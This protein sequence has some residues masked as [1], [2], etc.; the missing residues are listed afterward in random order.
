MKATPGPNTRMPAAN[1]V[2]ALGSAESLVIRLGLLAFAGSGGFGL[3]RQITTTATRAT[4]PSASRK[5]Y[6]VE[7]W[8]GMLSPAARIAMR[9]AAPMMVTATMPPST[10]STVM[11]PGLAEA[12]Y[13]AAVS[14]ASGYNAAPT[15]ASAA[16]CA[17]TLHRS[18]G[19]SGRLYGAVE[20]EHG[21]D[22]L[23]DLVRTSSRLHGHD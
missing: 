15:P 21:D 10:N 11:R 16:A 6:L 7:L 14:S 20:G 8:A 1:A 5:P 17:N 12:R 23:S 3:R 22:L 2:S 4:I 13:S 18:L 9:I 19:E